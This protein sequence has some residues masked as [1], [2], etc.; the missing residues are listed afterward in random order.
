MFFKLYTL[1]TKKDQRLGYFLVLLMLIG[2]SLEAIGIGLLV[3]IL[4][5]INNEDTFSRFLEPLTYFVVDQS[6]PEFIM[7]LFILLTIFF[8]CKNIFLAI[9]YWFQYKYIYRARANLSIKIFSW[10]LHESIFFHKS[11]N[12]S[13]LL[14]NIIND[15]NIFSSHGVLPILIIFTESFVLIAV[16]PGFNVE[17]WITF[18]LMILVALSGFLKSLDICLAILL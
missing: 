14:N 18:Y 9:M 3:P 5:A 12:S 8:L 16:N 13:K 1:L 4:S 15:T 10:Y 17:E 11:R 7:L 2:A 6:S